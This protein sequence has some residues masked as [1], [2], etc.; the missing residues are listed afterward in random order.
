MHAYGFALGSS[1]KKNAI[2]KL[3]NPT[4]ITDSHAEACS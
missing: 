4:V 1:E 2:Q 3:T